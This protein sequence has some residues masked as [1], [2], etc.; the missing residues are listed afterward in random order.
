MVELSTVEATARHHIAWARRAVLMIDIVESVRLIEQD[1]AGTIA[2]WLNFVEHVK[3]VVLPPR[4]GRVVKSLGDGLLL[5][6][7]DVR[8]AVSAALAIQR[9]S[10]R[11]NASLPADRRMDL[12]MGMEVC[13]VVIEVG[14][15]LGRGVNLA[16]RLMGLAGPGE[17]VVSP[18]VREGLTPSLDAEVEDLGDCF[19]RHVAEPIRAYRIGPPGP[20][21]A[22][23]ARGPVEDLAPAIAVIPF[24]ARSS[25][26]GHEMVGDILAEEVIRTLSHST[27]LNLVSRLSTAAFSGRNVPLEDIAGHLRADYVLRGTYALD[28]RRASV[29][30]ELAEASS[31][32]ILWL[33][34]FDSHVAAILGEEQEL[35]ERIVAGVKAAVAKRELQRSRSQPLPTLRAYTLLMGAV[36]LMHRLSLPDFEESYRLLQALVD[37]GVRHPIPAAWLANWH[38]LR[39][40]QGWSN[41]ERQDSYMAMEAT[42][43]ALDIDPDCSLALAINGFVHV[44]LLKKLDDAEQ[45]Y[46]RAI[47]ANPSNSLAWLLKGT[48]HAFKGEGRLAV[49]HTERALKLS[50]LDPHRYFYDSLAASAA[51]AAGQHERALE[52]AQSSLLANRKHTSTW[53]VITVAHW[54]LGQFEDAGRCARELMKLQPSMT[55]SGWLKGSPA[56]SYSIGREIAHILREA[57]IPE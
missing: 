51:L 13:D 43:R 11:R 17:I 45:S 20:H 9:E 7:E 46:E 28:D 38:V 44:N 23:R 27:D 8:S 35:I 6:F 26:A 56:A 39:V 25:G 24:A 41:D 16:A 31:G 55:V 52:L 12:R 40:Q 22:L 36:S 53:R 34:R 32:R 48:L 54:Q 50:P 4:E 57:G 42:K 3:S 33:D 21:S 18:S 1:E 47:A 19:V 2:R 10:A 29:E 14:D 15:I 30:V 37:R 49:S 5:D